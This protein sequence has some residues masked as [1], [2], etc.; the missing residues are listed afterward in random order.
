MTGREVERIDA[1]T[2]NKRGIKDGKCGRE[3]LVR[4]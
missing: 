4:Q 2:T 1:I 3:K